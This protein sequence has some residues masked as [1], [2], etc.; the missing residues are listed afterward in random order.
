MVLLDDVFLPNPPA[1]PLG[2]K[3]GQLDGAYS[4]LTGIAAY[5]S[6]DSGRPVKIAELVDESLLT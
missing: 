6:I 2:R 4:I 5:R 3:A 1:D